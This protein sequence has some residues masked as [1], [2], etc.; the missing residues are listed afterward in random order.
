LSATD[1]APHGLAPLPYEVN[2]L[3]WVISA[4]T[5]ERHHGRHHRGYVDAL[6]AL[7]AGT[8]WAD[9]SLQETIVATRGQ[10]ATAKIYNNASQ[11]WNHAFHWQS[12]K[13]DG[14]GKPPAAM[15]PLVEASFGSVAGCTD[16]LEAAAAA[17][18]GSGWVWL[19]AEGGKLAV[20]HTANADGPAAPGRKPLLVIDVWEHA[21]YLDYQERRAAYVKAVIDKL[22][23]W[24]FAA[25]NLG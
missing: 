12:L 23:N 9:M 24:G 18:L 10:I 8:D 11:A 4:R 22:L 19:V 15:V 17:R 14:G 13:P 2:A 5:L 25:D 6:N 1:A 3:E 16:A 7:V 20:E 21:Y